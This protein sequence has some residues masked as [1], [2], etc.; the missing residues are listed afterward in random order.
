M[1]QVFFDCVCP[2]IVNPPAPDKPLYSGDHCEYG[3]QKNGHTL[4]EIKF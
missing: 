3:K 1:D 2:A 4:K